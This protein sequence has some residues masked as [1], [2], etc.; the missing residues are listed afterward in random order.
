MKVYVL[1]E[2][3]LQHVGYS[4]NTVKIF[5]THGAA[6]AEMARMYGEALKKFNTT[7]D[8]PLANCFDASGY[9]YVA[10][11]DYRLDVYECVLDDCDLL[12][13]LQEI[14]V[15][16]EERGVRSK[17]MTE[18]SMSRPEVWSL[19][20]KWAEEYEARYEDYDYCGNNTSV[21]DEIDAFV[22]EKYEDLDKPELRADEM[23]VDHL[24]LCDEDKFGDSEE[25][26]VTLRIYDG[27]ATGDG[28]Y[29]EFP[30]LA[31]LTRAQIEEIDDYLGG[32]IK[33]S[34][35]VC[36]DDVCI[37]LGK[38]VSFSGIMDTGQNHDPELVR[39][40]NLAWMWKKDKFRPILCALY[41]RDINEITDS[42]AFL[43]DQWKKWPEYE[44][45]C[46]S[47][48]WKAYNDRAYAEMQ[49]NWEDYAENYLKH[50][51]DG[52]DLQCILDFV[53][54]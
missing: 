11:A 14:T 33:D 8:N 2:I 43:F 52:K 5:P 7:D 13:N 29:L 46:V 22:Q 37:A 39:R 21:Y 30:K 4:P 18:R 12:Q 20:Q 26:P 3:D 36:P 15:V 32:R 47:K 53:R 25:H 51:A 48:D 23:V 34:G 38:V 54:G 31:D 41:E 45:G 10:D 49:T 19:M 1:T 44:A 50:V 16:A 24:Y 27:Y 9:A 17:L 35:F 6:V 42:D 40:I 28:V